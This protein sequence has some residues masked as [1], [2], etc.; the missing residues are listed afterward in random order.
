M[1]S[2]VRLVEASRILEGFRP[3]GSPVLHENAV[4]LIRDGKVAAIGDRRTIGDIPDDV[5]RLGG[6]DTVVVPGLINAHHH[7]GFTPFQ[8]GSPDMPLELWFATRMALR[9][10]DLRLDTLFSAFEML[11]SGVTSVQH[12]HSRAPGDAEAVLAASRTVI[13][14]YREIGM[15]VSYSMALRNQ[16]RLVYGDDEAFAASLPPDLQP[17]IRAHFK[18]F[19][20]PL[21]EQIRIFE[22]LRAELHGDERLRLQLGPANLHWLSDEALE[23]AADLSQR[24]DMPLH[25]HLLE[26]PYQQAYAQRRTGG[27]ALAYL[28]RFGLLSPRMTLGHAVWMNEDDIGLAADRGICICHNCSSNMRLK[29]GR[30]PVQ[31]F[32]AAGIPVALGIDEAGINDD[33]DMLQ[34]MRLVHRAHR[35]PGHDTPDLSAAQIFRMATE[36]GARTLPFGDSIGRL[37]EGCAADLVLLDWRAVTSPYQHAESPLLDV[38]VNRARPDAIRSVLVAGE[39]LYQDGAFTRLSRRAVLDEIERAFARPLSHAER[40]RPLLAEAILPHV[41]KFYEGWLQDPAL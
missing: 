4:L 25:M 9:D 38:I 6:R 3:D 29:S 28:D 20:L 23:A 16:N 26:T 11:A 15:R 1:S 8:L 10:V 37:G 19:T 40:E 18:R 32:I 27:S 30:A 21:A 35:M 41:R 13:G 31:R 34:E 2:R 17:A 14:A 22:T 12:L 5:E 7:V 33:R 24:H 36:G 39:I